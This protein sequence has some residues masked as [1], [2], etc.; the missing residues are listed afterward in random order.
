MDAPC[1]SL[2]LALSIQ[3]APFSSM[4]NQ[5]RAPFLAVRRGAHRLFGK[6]RS[7]LRAAAARRVFAVLRN[8]IRDETR[9][10]KPPLPLLLLYFYFWSR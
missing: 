1:C 4:E 9:G 7:K 3:R 6:I 10:D 5:Q 8:P 2:R